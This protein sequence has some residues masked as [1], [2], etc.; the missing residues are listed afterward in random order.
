MALVVRGLLNKQIAAGLGTSE[1]TVKIQRGRMMRNMR[2][3]SVPDRVRM[4]QKLTAREGAPGGSHQGVIPSNRP[5][6]QAGAMESP[7][8]VPIVDDDRSVG[9]ATGS[10]VRANGLAE[11]TFRSAAALVAEGSPRQVLPSAGNG[12]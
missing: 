11:A 6:W 2:A 4:V 3:E 8:L 12:H 7:F 9:E 5:G 10:L 1:V